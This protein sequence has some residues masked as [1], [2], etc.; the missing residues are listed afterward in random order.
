MR[1]FVLLVIVGL[2]LFLMWKEV[3]ME[4]YDST[5]RAFVPIGCQRYGLRGDALHPEHAWTRYQYGELQDPP[6]IPKS[7][8]KELAK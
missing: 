1:A 7:I 8:I 4:S 6:V 2:L 3:S 5:T